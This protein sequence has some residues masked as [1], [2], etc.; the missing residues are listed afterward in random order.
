MEWAM[1]KYARFQYLRFTSALRVIILK[2]PV[3]QR[4][5]ASTS[6]VVRELRNLVYI[7]PRYLLA[8]R[9]RQPQSSVLLLLTQEILC[10]KR[11]PVS[12]ANFVIVILRILGNKYKQVFFQRK[13]KPFGAMNGSTRL[14]WPVIQSRKLLLPF[15]RKLSCVPCSEKKVL[16]TVLPLGR[17]LNSGFT[18]TGRVE[19]TTRLRLVCDL[20]LFILLFISSFI[21]IIP[22][23]Y[24]P[25]GI[26]TRIKIY[27]PSEDRTRES[28]IWFVWPSD[29]PTSRT[30]PLPVYTVRHGVSWPLEF[31]FRSCPSDR[32]LPQHE[33]PEILLMFLLSLT[34]TY[35]RPFPPPQGFVLEL[36]HCHINCIT[37]GPSLLVL[38]QRGEE[39]IPL[40]V[41][42]SSLPP[43]H[44]LSHFISLSLGAIGF[45]IGVPLETLCFGCDHVC[46]YSLVHYTS[47]LFRVPEYSLPLFTGADQPTSQCPRT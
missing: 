2:S 46:F 29:V 16:G 22:P 28:S 9:L 35:T 25:V 42:P 45:H 36:L 41:E 14:A 17:S 12:V 19:S 15:H 30:S 38:G 13:L 3:G 7:A 47:F 8:L 27:L 20:L 34:P 37:Q 5:A 11:R 44:I 43:H 4:L 40:V 6:A 23:C 32:C 10:K 1:R 26:C 21:N 33:V 39:L 24:W 31:G 18:A